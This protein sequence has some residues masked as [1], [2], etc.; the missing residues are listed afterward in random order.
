MLILRS[1]CLRTQKHLLHNLF[2]SCHHS[3]SRQNFTSKKVFQALDST[4]LI[5]ITKCRS[6]RS[7]LI[8]G[9]WNIHNLFS[10]LRL[11]KTVHINLNQSPLWSRASMNFFIIPCF[12]CSREKDNFVLSTKRLL[13]TF[14]SLSVK[15]FHDRDFSFFYPVILCSPTV[16]VAKGNKSIWYNLFACPVEVLPF[17]NWLQLSIHEHDIATSLG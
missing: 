9:P 13:M 8:W 15:L 7:V 12:R 16:P 5:F 14:L 3:S 1:K 6:L 17:S 4:A 2:D 11:G 10:S